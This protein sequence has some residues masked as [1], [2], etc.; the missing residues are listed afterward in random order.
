M[1]TVG[2]SSLASLAGDVERTLRGVFR[3]GSPLPNSLSA[4][5]QRGGAASLTCQFLNSGSNRQCIR[6]RLTTVLRKCI[7]AM[8]S[9]S[10]SRFSKL[11]RVAFGLAAS[12]PARV[13][14]RGC[15]IAEGLREGRGA[16]EVRTTLSKG[17]RGRGCSIGSGWP[18]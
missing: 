4:F 18:L 15:L 14:A 2:S 5:E 17:M 13:V 1:R 10:R 7:S 3:G 8:I 9:C 16:L 12:D 6:R 11:F